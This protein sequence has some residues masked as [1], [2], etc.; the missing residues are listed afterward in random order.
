MIRHDP[1]QTSICVLIPAAQS[2]RSRSN[3][4]R[5]PRAAAAK[6]RM[7]ISESGIVASQHHVEPYAA[8]SYPRP[9]SSKPLSKY[10]C[11]TMADKVRS[12]IDENR[13]A[14][15]NAAYSP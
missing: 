7:S 2:K 14:N 10:E 3:P 15:G 9:M 11:T 4:I 12:D 13:K 1:T 8:L 6:S 5:L